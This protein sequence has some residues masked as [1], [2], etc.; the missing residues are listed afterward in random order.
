MHLCSSRSLLHSRFGHVVP[1]AFQ[2][3]D[4]RSLL[5]QVPSPTYLLRLRCLDFTSTFIHLPPTSSC[6]QT[7]PASLQNRFG[8]L[9]N[10]ASKHQLTTPCCLVPLGQAEFTRLIQSSSYYLLSPPTRQEPWLV[11]PVGRYFYSV[12]PLCGFS[13]S[14]VYWWCRSQ[15]FSSFGKDQLTLKKG[16]NELEVA[17]QRKT[18]GRRSTCTTCRRSGNQRCA[19][20][21]AGT[22][23][24]E[25]RLR[26]RVCV[27]TRCVVCRKVTSFI[28]LH[29][30]DKGTEVSVSRKS[31]RQIRSYFCRVTRS[32]YILSRPRT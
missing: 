14:S 6:L 11:P 13:S 18:Q 29:L 24:R 30:A 19:K 12:C 3:L 26:V 20:G 31:I 16:D 2:E 8:N 28:Y 25:Q 10:T 32:S 21:T 1:N 4:A 17:Q 5:R 7:Q 9:P 22:D 15:Q 23:G 27:T